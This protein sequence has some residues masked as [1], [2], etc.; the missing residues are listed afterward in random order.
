[1]F[2]LGALDIPTKTPQKESYA[3]ARLEDLTDSE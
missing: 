1:M 3:C 2:T